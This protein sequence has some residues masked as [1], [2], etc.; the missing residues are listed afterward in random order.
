MDA[1]TVDWTAPAGTEGLRERKKRQ[2]RQRLTDTATEMFLDR[3]F[4]AVRVAE[5]AAACG[6]SEKTVYNYFPNKEALVV[7]H[8]EAAIQA[9]RTGL[10]D[11]ARRPVEVVL[12]ILADELAAMTSWLATQQD[13]A[14]AG[15]RI[16]RFTTL[17]QTTPSLR[18]YQHDMTDRLATVA[19]QTLAERTG[20]SPDDPEPRITATALLGLWQIQFTALRR[21]LDGTRDLEQVRQA[22]TAEV[23]RAADLVD[24]GLAAF[25][26]RTSGAD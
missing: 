15:A 12:G 21:Y 2:L 10:A 25:A 24:N 5:I 11:L 22:V 26:P 16:R 23:R 7:D 13:H 19:A 14:K 1:R 17:I 18:A 6:V 4:E 9:L 3:G 8:P 20:M